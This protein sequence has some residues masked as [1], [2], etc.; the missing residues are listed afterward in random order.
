MKVHQVFS[1]CSLHRY[2]PKHERFFFNLKKNRNKNVHRNLQTLSCIEN[3][4]KKLIK[5][6][7]TCSDEEIV[8]LFLYQTKQTGRKSVEESK[9]NATWQ[10]KH[11]KQEKWG[12]R[13]GYGYYGSRSIAWGIGSQ[14]QDE[15]PTLSLNE[16]HLVR[17]SNYSSWPMSFIQ[18]ESLLENKTPICLK[19][20]RMK[21][22]SALF[23]TAQLPHPSLFSDSIVFSRSIV[24][25]FEVSYLRSAEL[26][27][28]KKLN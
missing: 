26:L 14:D 18:I 8:P 27:K 16:K 10:R 21:H 11:L 28:I 24:P 1:T 7:K 9:R 22:V 13:L 23:L 19:H 3:T 15:C 12:S 4:I 6:F 2:K 5:N 25:F 20:A 17:V